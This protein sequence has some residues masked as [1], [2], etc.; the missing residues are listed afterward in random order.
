MDRPAFVFL[1]A[2][3]VCQP[4]HAGSPPG[5]APLRLAQYGK[6][7]GKEGASEVLAFSPDGRMIAVGKEPALVLYE[8]ASLLE[9]G[10]LPTPAEDSVR[11]VA[12]LNHGRWALVAYTGRIVVW[13]LASR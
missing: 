1:L 7:K 8:T 6:L 10:R 5:P 2:L 11:K 13:D 3:F 12:F 9:R 4:A